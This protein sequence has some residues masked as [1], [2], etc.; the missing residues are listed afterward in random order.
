MAIANATANQLITMRKTLAD[1]CMQLDQLLQKRNTAT[2]LDAA[3]VTALGAAV[4]A[5][6]AAIDAV[7]AA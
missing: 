3:E 6:K 2:A 7:A 5:V 4:T 1:M